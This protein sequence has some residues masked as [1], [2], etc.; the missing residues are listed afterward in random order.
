[1][2]W[3]GCERRRSCPIIRYQ[4]GICLEGLRK[5]TKDLSQDSRSPGQ[6][7]NLGFK[8]GVL[9]TQQRRSVFDYY[10]YI[11]RVCDIFCAYNKGLGKLSKYYQ[12]APTSPSDPLA[13][14]PRSYQNSVRMPMVFFQLET[15]LTPFMRQCQGPVASF[16]SRGNQPS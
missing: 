3:K 1:M 7:L 16:W 2:N 5:T 6:H 15:I 11:A 13:V 4:P 12:G 9:T 8:A 14:H 10:S